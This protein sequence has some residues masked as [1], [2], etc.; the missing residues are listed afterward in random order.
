M[1]KEFESIYIF[2]P[3][4]SILWISLVMGSN[5]SKQSPTE[6]LKVRELRLLIQFTPAS[7]IHRTW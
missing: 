1:T 4:A 3:V 5:I 6:S 7:G 2:L